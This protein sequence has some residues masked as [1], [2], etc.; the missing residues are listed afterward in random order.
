[1]NDNVTSKNKVSCSIRQDPYVHNRYWSFLRFHC[2][3]LKSALRRHPIQVTKWL[4]IC[5][6]PPWN[7]ILLC[8]N[9]TCSY[10]SG[11]NFPIVTL[12]HEWIRMNFSVNMKTSHVKIVLILFCRDN[13]H[14]KISNQRS[15]Q[16]AECFVFMIPMTISRLWKLWDVP[17]PDTEDIVRFKS[18]IVK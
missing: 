16:K 12:K 6:K 5:M 7:S 4:K 9:I 3:L 18:W 14:R 2:Q 17:D 1:M 13:W 11:Q 10:T 15:L 8:R